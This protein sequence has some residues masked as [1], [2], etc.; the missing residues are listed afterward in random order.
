MSL[1]NATEPPP[2]PTDPS[3]P[4]DPA[5]ASTEL[6]A[7]ETR[8]ARLRRQAL[9]L[10]ERTQTQIEHRR[11]DLLPV[12]VAVLYYER[13]REALASVL[14]SAVALRLYL[15]IIS[16]MIMTVGLAIVVIGK[17]QLD[18]L[19]STASV[20]GTM[21]KDISDAASGTTGA[22]LALLLTGIWL[23]LWTGRNL[24]KVLAACAVRS[25]RMDATEAKAG[26]TAIASL[27]GLIMVTL[28]VTLVLG[29]V[30]DHHGIAA[31]V[32][33]WVLTGAI[34]AATWFAVT[35]FL[36]R[37]TPDPGALLPGA[38]FMGVAMTVLQWFMQFYLPNKISRSSDLAGDL[39]PTM[40]ALG[41]LFF[42]G[43][44]MASSFVLD[45]VLFERVGSISRFVFSIPLIRAIPRRYGAVARFFDLPDAPPKPVA[46]GAT[47][48]AADVAADPPASPTPT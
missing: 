22:G 39:G 14:G 6:E 12:D 1:A 8:T 2:D 19:L 35:W 37:A 3:D 41:Y 15:F 48:P 9:D 27:S 10:S 40:A 30:R 47:D 21:A 33:S 24:T 17:D 4:S 28:A 31:G 5:V 25:W 20:S 38:A 32:S 36:P 34:L 18:Q 7:T 26:V 44:A 43:R 23:V 13:D 16:A 42:V 46:A 29:R 45:A 11:Q